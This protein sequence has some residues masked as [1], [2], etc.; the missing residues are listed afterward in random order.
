VRV[1][2]ALLERDGR[3]LV[4]QRP[5]HKSLGLKWEFPGGKIESGETGAACLAR[6]LR[7]ELGVDVD[8]GRAFPPITHD[9]GDVLIELH[10]FI[11][12]LRSGEPQPHEHI[13]VRWCTTDE[14][15]ALDLAAA[16]VPVL[17]EYMRRGGAGAP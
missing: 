7:E 16:D 17:A 9:Y 6:E 5:A 8:I 1:T 2:C 13:A 3:L 12:Q 14:I 11:C 10:A 4:A 15:A